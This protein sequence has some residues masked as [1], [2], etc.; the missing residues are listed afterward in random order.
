MNVSS[1]TERRHHIRSDASD[2]SLPF[3]WLDGACLTTWNTYRVPA[4]GADMRYIEEISTLGWPQP[5]ALWLV[6]TS[7]I[8]VGPCWEFVV[9]PQLRALLEKMGTGRQSE[10]ISI[11]ERARSLR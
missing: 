1:L 7:P 4:C 11:L 10:L 3:A 2:D 9:C 6:M 8:A 5:H